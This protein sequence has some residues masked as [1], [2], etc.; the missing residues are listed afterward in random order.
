MGPMAIGIER[1][2]GFQSFESFRLRVPEK[3]G[4]VADDATPD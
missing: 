4:L 1:A 3:T 2:P